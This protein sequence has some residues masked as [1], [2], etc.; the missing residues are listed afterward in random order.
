MEKFIGNMDAKADAKGRVFVPVVFRRILHLAEETQLILR[1]NESQDCLTL[2]SKTQW[3]EE[4][5]QLRQKLN[6]WDAEQQGLFRHFSS[7]VEVMEMDGNGRILIPKKYL[8]MTGITH[9][10]RFVGMYDS[11]EL[12]NP[13][14]LEKANLSLKDSQDSIKRFLVNT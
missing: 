7:Q 10:V 1:K 8:Q 12:W 13:D 9:E 4:L 6:K 11:I 2:F 14:R 5:M 3:E